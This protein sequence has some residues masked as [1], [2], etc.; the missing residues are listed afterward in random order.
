MIATLGRRFH[1]RPGRRLC[2]E[3]EAQA[4]QSAEARVA[5]LEV[6]L[7]QLQSGCWR[8]P[9]PSLS[10]PTTFPNQRGKSP[11]CAA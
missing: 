6:H 10:S 11:P 3:E 9:A 7:R 1:Q 8:P 5:E 4:R 2:R